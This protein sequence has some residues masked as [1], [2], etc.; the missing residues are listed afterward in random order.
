MWVEFDVGS[1]TLTLTLS[2]SMCTT[3]P[4][5]LLRSYPFITYVFTLNFIEVEND[6]RFMLYHP[7][8][9]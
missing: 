2:Q 5:L 6:A 9:F 4:A 1:L 7:F 3:V 8:P